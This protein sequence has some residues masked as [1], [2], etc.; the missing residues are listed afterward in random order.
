MDSRGMLGTS[1]L[2]AAYAEEYAFDPTGHVPALVS[3]EWLA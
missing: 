2:Y 3:V 1:V